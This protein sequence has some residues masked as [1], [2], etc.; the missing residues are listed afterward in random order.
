MS[1]GPDTKIQLEGNGRFNLTGSFNFNIV[2]PIRNQYVID[3][4]IE[5]ILIEG[6]FNSRPQYAQLFGS[7]DT[8]NFNKIVVNNNGTAR[9]DFNRLWASGSDSFNRF[10]DWLNGNYLK[11]DINRTDNRY[12]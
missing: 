5:Q 9:P 4:T 11:N 3:Y 12:K 6:F 8:F 7:F 1:L 10:R 2:D